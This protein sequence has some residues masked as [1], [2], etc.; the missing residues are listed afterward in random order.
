MK[1]GRHDGVATLR[2]DNL[3]FYPNYP[4]L[5]AESD[6]KTTV[7]SNLDTSCR[8]TESFPLCWANATTV[9]DI[10]DILHARLF[11]PFS[12]VLCHTYM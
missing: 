1:K 9:H 5:F 11:C 12:N 10:Y 6:P 3:S 2:V 7:I 4:T 8:E